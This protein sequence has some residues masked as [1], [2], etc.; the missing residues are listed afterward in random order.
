M[1]SNPD[2]NIICRNMFNSLHSKRVS[3]VTTSV[4]TL[5]EH[6]GLLVGVVP[7]DCLIVLELS[8]FLH[9]PC[10]SFPFAQTR[11]DVCLQ[12]VHTGTV[13]N[14]PVRIAMPL[15]VLGVVI[16]PPGVVFEATLALLPPC[17]QRESQVHVLLEANLDLLLP[18]GLQPESNVRVESLVG[19]LPWS[20]SSYS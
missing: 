20:H 19:G 6:T 4:R 18:L 1:E 17:L 13:V 16:Y 11:V 15:V 14:D 3:T 9:L 10:R 8:C 7:V 2:P 12:N 5:H